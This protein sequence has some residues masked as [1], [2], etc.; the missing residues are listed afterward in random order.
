MPDR[1]IIRGGSLDLR[2]RPL[3][4]A[5][6][7]VTPDSFSDG[8][9]FFDLRAAIA[10]G[11]RL[12]EEGAAILDVGGE[13]TRPGAEPVPL[14]EELRRVLP[15]VETL[16]NTVEVPISIDTCKAA[17]A[18]QAI[19]AGAR[20]INDVTALRGDPDMLQV[21]V[22]TAAGVCLMHMKG[23]PRTMMR[24]VTYTDVVREVALFLQQRCDELAAAGIPR[25]RLAIDPGLGFFA[26]TVEHNWQLISRLQELR[27]IGYPLVVGHSRKRFIRQIVGEDPQAILTGTVG[28]GLLLAAGGVDILRVHDVRPLR[29]ALDAVRQAGQ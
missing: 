29:S 1:W 24:E 19:D 27:A 18:R 11:Q 10:H 13:S 3:L 12:A 28:V 25:D 15:V 5:I 22:E 14:A 23:T 9:Q 8:G 16:A 20:I 4:M 2:R 17:V 26:K 21:A 6:I 7:N